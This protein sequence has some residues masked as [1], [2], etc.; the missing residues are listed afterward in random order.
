MATSWNVIL[1]VVLLL[2]YMPKRNLYNAYICIP[3]TLKCKNKGI[4]MVCNIQ[5]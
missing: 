5:M 2:F 3:D 4:E 1:M